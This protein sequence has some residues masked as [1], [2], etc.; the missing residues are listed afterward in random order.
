MNSNHG[1]ASVADAMVK[2][3]KIDTIRAYEACRKAI[4]EKTLMPWSATPA[5]DIDEFYHT[6]GYIPALPQGIEET[7]GNVNRF[8]KRQ[9]VAVTLGTAYDE[10]CLSS[11]AAALVSFVRVATTVTSSMLLPDSSTPRTRTATGLNRST[12]VGRADKA[13]A[14]IMARTTDGFTV[15][16]CLTT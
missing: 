11:I 2:G 7:N 8:E 3:L 10:W 16:M 12:T 14:N 1:V 4:E 6:Q 5:N 9:P 13:H 15:G